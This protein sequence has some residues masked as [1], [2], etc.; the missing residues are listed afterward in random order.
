MPNCSDPEWMI[1]HAH[2]IGWENIITVYVLGAGPGLQEPFATTW[3]YNP[4]DFLIGAQKC[5]FMI[6]IGLHLK[7][8]M[9]RAPFKVILPGPRHINLKHMRRHTVRTLTLLAFHHYS[10]KTKQLN[11]V[12]LI[13]I[14]FDFV[15]A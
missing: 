2:R 15:M 6:I 5:S 4:V 1:E 11:Q 8:E 14:A 12:L 9:M 10:G 3:E 13:Q 7:C